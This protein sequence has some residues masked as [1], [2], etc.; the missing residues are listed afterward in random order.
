MKTNLRLILA[1][2]VAIG[3]YVW[4]PGSLAV[5]GSR[6]AA[7][8]T[9]SWKLVTFDDTPPTE[10]SLRWEQDRT[11]V[12]ARSDGGASGL[13]AELPGDL[14]PTAM[15]WRWRVD[16]CL[17]ND[18]ER[19]RA[20]DDFAARVFVLYG[21]ERAWTPWGWLRRRMVDNPFGNVVPKRVVNYVWASG[22]E[23]GDVY[24]NPSFRNVATVVVESDC[25]TPGEWVSEQR[26]LEADFRL[27][28]RESMPNVVGVAVMTDTDDTG[29]RAVTWYADITLHLPSG[30]RLELPFNEI[31]R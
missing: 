10:Y 22:G 24:P 5:P 30:E 23:T 20:G 16:Q 14:H 18:Q 4:M 15:S 17:E 7:L 28:Y 25:R 2:G 9:V 27:A 19:V 1:I 8:A 26:E 12:N 13:V 3:F 11:V 21:R 6:A 29:G 31:V